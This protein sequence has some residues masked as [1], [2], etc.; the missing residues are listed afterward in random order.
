MTYTKE[1]LAKAFSIVLLEQVPDLSDIP[2][3]VFSER[4]EKRMKKLVAREATHP[5]AIRHP[6]AKNLIAAVI[7]IILL[8]ALSMSVGAVRDKVVNFFLKHFQDHDEITFDLP[9]KDTI[10]TEY[11]ISSIPQ[12]FVLLSKNSANPSIISWTYSNENGS[13]I[14]FRQYLASP[15]HSTTIDNERT[16]MKTIE[17]DDQI[18]FVS[19]DYKVLTLIWDYDGYVFWL[20]VDK[21]CFSLETTIEIYRSVKPLN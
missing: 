13:T 15:S 18:V 19:E 21:N 20:M 6:V 3:H 17:V 1:Q 8:F 7:V 4:F 5:W 14:L 2:D 9:Q 10:E 11:E 12:G 16:Q